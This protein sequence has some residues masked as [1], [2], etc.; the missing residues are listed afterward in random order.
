MFDASGYEVQN[1]ASDLFSRIL[2]GAGENGFGQLA[3][4]FF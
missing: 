4:L 2:R 1:E 3:C